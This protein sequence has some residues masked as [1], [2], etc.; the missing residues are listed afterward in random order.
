MVGK[1]S[2]KNCNNSDG[3]C[4][5]DFQPTTYMV[6]RWQPACKF[7]VV[8]MY[9]KRN[10]MKCYETGDGRKKNNVGGTITG[11]GEPRKELF[12]NP[13]LVRHKYHSIDTEI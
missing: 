13:N 3:N 4:L 1:N 9:K 10:E 7:S 2:I 8:M 6:T 12:E 11:M 5:C